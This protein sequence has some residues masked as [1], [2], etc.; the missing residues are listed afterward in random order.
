MIFATYYFCTGLGISIS[1][2]VSQ[3][4][5]QFQVVKH[6]GVY[7]YRSRETVNFPQADLDEAARAAD[8]TREVIGS[9]VARGLR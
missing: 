2:F 4:R 8:A 9:I 3:G 7:R 1:T 5:W 6:M